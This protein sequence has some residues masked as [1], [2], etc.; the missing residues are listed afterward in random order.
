MKKGGITQKTG[1]NSRVEE[2]LQGILNAVVEGGDVY[3]D[4]T[5]VSS[6]IN[7]ANYN[8]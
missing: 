1:G 2:L 5:K 3:M 8:A 4:G 7:S 6:A